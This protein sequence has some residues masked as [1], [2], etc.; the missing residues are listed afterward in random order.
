[1]AVPAVTEQ[2]RQ[3]DPESQAAAVLA[4]MDEVMAQEDFDDDPR[5]LAGSCC[6][7]MVFLAEMADGSDSRKRYVGDIWDGPGCGQRPEAAVPV[8]LVPKVMA[9]NDVDGLAAQDGPQD[10]EAQFRP[11]DFAD[12]GNDKARHESENGPIDRQEG[13][14]RQAGHIRDGDHEDTDEGRIDAKG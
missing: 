2:D 11:Q 6:Q 5:Y 12:P 14:R 4:D 3:D 1:M 10:N 9:G 7:K 8:E 13:N